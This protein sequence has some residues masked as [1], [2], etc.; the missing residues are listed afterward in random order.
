MIS[1]LTAGAFRQR[2]W[3]KH[4]TLLVHFDTRTRHGELFWGRENDQRR[5]LAVLASSVPA[6]PFRD[7]AKLH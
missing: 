5:I 7:R 4:W 2:S 1:K 6:G 3:L